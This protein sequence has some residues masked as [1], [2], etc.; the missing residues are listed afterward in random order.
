MWP[1]SAPACITGIN[2]RSFNYPNVRSVI[3]SFGI[4]TV[5]GIDGPFG[6]ENAGKPFDFQ[7]KN[8]KFWY[9]TGYT[10]QKSGGMLGQVN[11]YFKKI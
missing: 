8:Y 4:Y 7:P 5:N 3:Y 10:T 11:F 6:N 2:G 1:S 9:I